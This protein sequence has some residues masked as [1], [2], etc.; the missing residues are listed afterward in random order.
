MSTD[1]AMQSISHQVGDLSWKLSSEGNN[2]HPNV[3]LDVS[4][5]VQA[6]VNEV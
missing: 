3:T 5:F 1:I 2:Y 4:T 6:N